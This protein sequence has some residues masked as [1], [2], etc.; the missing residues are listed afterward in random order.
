V[1]VLG[2]LVDNAMDA[3]AESEVRR[4]VVSL[5][6]EGA[7]VRIRVEDSGPGLADPL[8]ERAF[9]RG[10][11]TKPS[12]GHDGR[13]LGLALVAQVVRRHDGHVE[14]RASALGGA[15]FEVLL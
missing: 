10:W 11:S 9:E 13:G 7:R 6:Q 2:N 3:V 4:V 8:V 1:T 14:V 15:C 5:V 12:D